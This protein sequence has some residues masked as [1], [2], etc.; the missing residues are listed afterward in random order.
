MASVSKEW[1]NIAQGRQ[2]STATLC[3]KKEAPFMHKGGFL[4]YIYAAA[5]FYTALQILST[6]V[7]YYK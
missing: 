7:D 4:F 1:L 5:I 6:I 2:N 3:R